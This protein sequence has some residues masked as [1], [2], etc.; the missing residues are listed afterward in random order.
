MQ[1]LTR[2]DLPLVTRCLFCGVVIAGPALPPGAEH[3]ANVG[4]C[5]RCQASIEH[6]ACAAGC[7]S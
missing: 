7:S 2:A 6:F 5:R 4:D 1:Q 3:V